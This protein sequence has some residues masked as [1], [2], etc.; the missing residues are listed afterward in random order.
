MDKLFIWWAIVTVVFGTLAD[1]S[2]SRFINR[3]GTALNAVCVYFLVRCWARDF[4]DVL[5]TVR[6]LALMVVPLAASMIVEK[7]TMRNIFSVFGGVAEFAGIR[8]GKLRCQGAFRHPI[9]AGTYGAT[10][11]PLF[12]GLWFSEKR[13]KWRA[14]LGTGSAVVV[15]LAA[16]SSG[17]FLALIAGTIGLALWRFRRYMRLIRLG[18][19]GML[20]LLALVMKAPVWYVFSRLSELVGGTGWYRS[21]IIDMAVKHF[22][23]WWLVGSAYTVHWAPAGEVVPGD[24]NNMD[25]I[26]NYIAEGLGGGVLKLGLFVAMIVLCFKVVGRLASRKSGVLPPARK[27]LMWS[28]GVCLFAHC[29]S[30][31]SVAYFDQIIV[32]WYWLLAVIAVF[33]VNQ[34]LRPQPRE[35]PAANPDN[36]ADA[37]ASGNQLEL[38]MAN[39]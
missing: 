4:D 38:G 36:P 7:F 10:L 27:I 17:A 19:V 33:S 8:D 11:F 12:V 5:H 22:D 29:I 39:A 34:R 23:E 21:Y 37:P 28:F 1:L 3:A 35:H 9:L 24:P 16:A 13:K 2:V 31:L 26:N 18:V 6:F 14:A 25:I 15:T 32:M 30:F 20:I